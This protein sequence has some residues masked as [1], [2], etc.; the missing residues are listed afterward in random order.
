MAGLDT[1]HGARTGAHH[2]R[3][4]AGAGAAVADAL[5][6]VAVGNTAGGEEDIIA[7]AE[8][9]RREDAVEIVAGIDRRA[10]LPVVAGPEAAEQ[11]P[12]PRLHPP[13][14]NKPLGRPA[15]SPH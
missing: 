13:V 5:Q 15:D 12:P 11:L 14:G 4:G 1:T 7:R 2:E 3:F 6:D 9:I 8:V 10:A